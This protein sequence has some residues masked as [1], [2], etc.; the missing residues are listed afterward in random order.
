MNKKEL[1]K[2]C[3]D[4]AKKQGFLLQPDPVLLDRI[5]EGLLNREKIYGLRYCPC[6][7]VTGDIEEDRKIVCPCI[8]HKEEIKDEGHCKCMLFLKKIE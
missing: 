6:R 8:Y 4:Y 1:K 3:Q 5:L 7:R 2:I